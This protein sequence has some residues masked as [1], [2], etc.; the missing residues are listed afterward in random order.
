MHQDYSSEAIEPQ[1]EEVVEYWR[2]HVKSGSDT[3][4]KARTTIRLRLYEGL[5]SA[6]LLKAA[7]RYKK[8]LDSP[9]TKYALAAHNFFSQSYQDYIGPGYLE[10]PVA[11]EPTQQGLLPANRAAPETINPIEWRSLGDALKAKRQQK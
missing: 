9:P 10:P 11:I 3:Y 5:T 2:A 4:T 6:D 7:E 1:V 8:E